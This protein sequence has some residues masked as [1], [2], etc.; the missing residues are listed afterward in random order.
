MKKHKGL[1]ISLIVLAV[2]GIIGFIG[3]K[4]LLYP[5]NNKN[6][7]G[8]RLSGI[9]NY[10]ISEKTINEMKESFLKNEFVT[11]FSYNLTGRIIKIIITVKSNTKVEQAQ[12]LSSIITTLLPSEYQSFYD[13]SY[14]I[15]SDEENN[16]YPVIGSKHKTKEMFSWTIKKEIIQEEKGVLDE[17]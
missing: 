13:I 7:Y 5:D 14:S 3:V 8:D 17:E 12:E 9:E 6:K 16:L 15:I 11:N 2:L 4:K 10:E 1:I